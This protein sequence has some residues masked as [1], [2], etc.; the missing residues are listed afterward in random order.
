VLLHSFMHLLAMPIITKLA[1]LSWD[2]LVQG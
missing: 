1:F 2:Q